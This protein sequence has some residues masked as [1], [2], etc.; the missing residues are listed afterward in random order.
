MSAAGGVERV[1]VFHARCALRG[2]AGDDL[3]AALHAECAAL[4]LRGAACVA[5]DGC[6]GA[7]RGD[8]DALH[9]LR[10]AI[11]TLLLRQLQR[12]DP[13]AMFQARA[14]RCE[15]ALRVAR[16]DVS[17]APPRRCTRATAHSQALLPTRRALSHSPSAARARSPSWTLLRRRLWLS[18]RL[19]RSMSHHPSRFTPPLGDH[20][21]PALRHRRCLARLALRRGCGCC[22][23]TA[24]GRAARRWRGTW[25]RCAAAWPLTWISS[26]WTRRTRC[27]RPPACAG[28]PRRLARPARDARG[29]SRRPTPPGAPR[30]TPLLQ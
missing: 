18:S 4:R 24:S 12:G 21:P 1:L 5:D 8:G 28:L 2:A 7:L 11:E 23:C 15:Y 17:C 27:R 10:R 29:C 22:A 9:R 16:A 25:R 26:S 20:P 19:L 3:A 30:A 14:R 6:S 13:S